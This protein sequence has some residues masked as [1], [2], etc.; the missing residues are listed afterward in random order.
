MLVQKSVETQVLRTRPWSTAPRAAEGPGQLCTKES[1]KNSATK[2]PL[3]IPFPA[4]RWEQK[5]ACPGG[6][7]ESGRDDD[8]LLWCLKGGRKRG[9]YFVWQK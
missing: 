2:K 4:E 5:P 6:Q 7:A 9:Q 1:S 8:P 3:M